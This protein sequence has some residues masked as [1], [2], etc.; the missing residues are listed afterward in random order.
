MSKNPRLDLVREEFSNQSEPKARLK[1]E[2][3]VRLTLAISKS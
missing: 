1:N 3:K 2:I